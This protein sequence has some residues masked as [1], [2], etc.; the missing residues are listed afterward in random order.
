MCG[1]ATHQESLLAVLAAGGPEVCLTTAEL[2]ARSG[3]T[4]KQVGEASGKLV[5]RNL[6][7]RAEVGCFRLTDHGRAHVAAG[8]PLT[9][10]PI[11]QFTA[12]RR[13]RDSLRVRAWRAMRMR[14]KFTIADVAGL[15]LRPGEREGEV[16]RYLRT[17]FRAGYLRRLAGGGPCLRYALVRDTGPEAPMLIDG[18]RAVRD[19][20]TGDTVAVGSG[21]D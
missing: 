20:N 11:K 7:E 18:R 10:A 14:G 6:I 16:Q 15:A 21:D 5:R 1:V 9:S 4:R 17:L 2:A 3:L 19:P 8:T 13:H 12:M